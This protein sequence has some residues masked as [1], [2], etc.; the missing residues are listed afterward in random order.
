MGCDWP[1]LMTDVVRNSIG[2]VFM[3]CIT[4]LVVL[5]DVIGGGCNWL[6]ILN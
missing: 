5:H 3:R 6:L 2:S 4:L 1:R